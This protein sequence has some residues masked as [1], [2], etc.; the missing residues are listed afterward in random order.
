MKVRMIARI[1]G[2]RDGEPWPEPGELADVPADEAAS[3]I[4]C[5]LAELPEPVAPEAAV[6]PKAETATTPKPRSRKA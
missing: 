5:K 6:A 2:L 1:S 3:L 4:E